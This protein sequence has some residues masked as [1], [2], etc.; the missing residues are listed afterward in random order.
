MLVICMLISNLIVINVPKVKCYWM[1][2]FVANLPAHV[3]NIQQ[4]LK[5][6]MH[7]KRWRELSG[8][9][10]AGTVPQPR[11]MIGFMADKAL[12]MCVSVCLSEREKHEASKHLRSSTNTSNIKLESLRGP[13]IWLYIKYHH[14]RTVKVEI[15]PF[16]ATESTK[17]GK[18][19]I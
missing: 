13:Q 9:S 3:Y 6:Q 8:N 14:T 1:Y 10:S 7:W 4:L 5:P 18:Y 17:N 15:C 16:S 11:E 12:R 2:L 19:Y